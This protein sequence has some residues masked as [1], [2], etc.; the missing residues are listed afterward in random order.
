MINEERLRSLIKEILNEL[1]YKQLKSEAPKYLHIKEKFKNNPG[2]KYKGAKKDGTIKFQTPSFTE[3]GKSY[4]QKVKLLDLKNLIKEYK[5][6][7]SRTEIV[8]MAVNGDIAVD[9]TDPSWKYWGFKYKGTKEGYSIGRET[10]FPRVRNPKLEGALCKHL[11]IG[12]NILPFIV[13]RIT[14]SLNKLGVF[15]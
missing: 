15:D 7:K 9:C 10:R 6:K 14:K 2:M 1:N 4:D 8:K 11:Y 3:P 13:S 5:G 12:V